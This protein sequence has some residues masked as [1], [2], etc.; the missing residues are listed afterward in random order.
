MVV[1]VVLAFEVD[2]SRM[3]A[4][5]FAI[6]FID[7]HSPN[8]PDETASAAPQPCPAHLLSLV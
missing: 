8:S 6:R 7:R 4:M 5:Y 2:E 3:L 1:G